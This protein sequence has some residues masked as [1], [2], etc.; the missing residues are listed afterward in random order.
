MIPDRKL[1]AAAPGQPPSEMTRL[2]ALWRKMSEEE[3]TEWSALLESDTSRPDIRRQIQARLQVILPH[4]VQVNRFRAWLASLEAHQLEAERMAEEA[5]ELARQ[6]LTDERLD[7]EIL[8]RT[9]IRA[10]VRGNYSL[11]MRAISQTIRLETLKLK[12]A[13]FAGGRQSNQDLTQS[14]SS[15]SRTTPQSSLVPRENRPKDR[16]TAISPAPARIAT[17]LVTEALDRVA[18]TPP[19]PLASGES[20][21][22]GSQPQF[23]LQSALDGSSLTDPLPPV[24]LILPVTNQNRKQQLTTQNNVH[25]VC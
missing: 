11:G 8:R 17:K 2:K 10:L 9:K 18:S 14:A 5:E 1:K 19:R 12:Q 22:W 4:D 3:Q 20:R 24:H 23:S 21:F 6:G 25:P 13:K 16:L 15:Q 7:Q